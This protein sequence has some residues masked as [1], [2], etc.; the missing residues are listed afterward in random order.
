MASAP[1]STV[2]RFLRSLVAAGP[3]KDLNDGQLLSRFAADRDEIAFEVLMRRHGPL[4]LSVVRRFLGSGP[5]LEDVFQATFLVLARKAG[6]INRQASVASWLYGV[7]FRLAQR[8][9]NRLARQRLRERSSETLEETAETRTMRDNPAEQARLRELGAILD[10]EVERLPRKNREALVLCHLEG[11][12]VAEAA[13]RLGCPLPTLKSRLTR[14][15]ELIRRR[16]VSRGLSVSATT[17]AFIL[18]EQAARAAVPAK[19]MSAAIDAAV[20]FSANSVASAAISAHAAALAKGILKTSVLAKIAFTLCIVL[21]TTLVGFGG[22][23]LTSKESGTAPSPD[24][25]PPA[26]VAFVQPQLIAKDLHGDVLPKGALARLGSTRWHHGAMVR[27]A[28]FLP[29][30]KRVISVSHDEIIHIWDYPSGKE[31]RAFGPGIRDDSQKNVR[32]CFDAALTA[33]GNTIAALF[34]QDGVRFWDVRTG[35]ELPPLAE[36]QK[37]NVLGLA[38]APDGRYLATHDIDFNVRIWDWTVEKEVRSFQ[39]QHKGLAGGPRTLAFA[40]DGKTLLAVVPVVRSAVQIPTIQLWDP[41]TGQR[42]SN[43][44]ATSND[45][46]LPPVFSPNSKLLAYGTGGEKGRG[47]AIVRVE[48]GKEIRRLGPVNSPLNVVFSLDSAKLLGRSFK[49]W[50]VREWDVGNGK[51]MRILGEPQD[52]QSRFGNSTYLALS[53]DGKALLAV[54]YDHALRLVDLNFG[55]TA[56]RL[57]YVLPIR[58][59]AF[60]PD[61]TQLVTQSEA[62]GVSH[63]DVGSGK[64]LRHIAAPP[65]EPASWTV[66]SP[67]GRYFTFN[68]DRSPRF[69]MVIE[70]ATGKQLGQVPGRNLAFSP[71][72]KTLAVGEWERKAICLYDLP[73]LK[74]RCSLP[75]QHVHEPDGESGTIRVGGYTLFFSPDSQ[76]F[77]TLHRDGVVGIWECANGKQVSQFQ[78]G[79]SPI[80]NVAFAPDA[81]ALAIDNRDGTVTIWEVASGQR[82]RVFGLEPVKEI[83]DDGVSGIY[84]P[85]GRRATAATLSYSPDG[86]LVAHAGLHKT[87]HVWDVATGMKAA[88]FHGH[89]GSLLCVAFS[90]DCTRLASGS[91]DTTALIWDVAGLKKKAG[92]APRYQKDAEVRACWEELAGSDAAKAFDAILALAADP[93]QTLLFLQPRLKTAPP[94]DG[95][96]AQLLIAQLDGEQYKVR[97]N[98]A[99]ELRQMGEQVLPLLEKTLAANP[100]LELRRRL[101]AVREYLS[102]LT[103]TGD[104]LR[105]VRSVEVLESIG[106]AQARK[107]LQSLADGPTWALETQT[108]QA[109]LRRWRN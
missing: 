5:D 48:D 40:P 46:D 9:K 76:F 10:E 39:T 37:Q 79:H 3:I 12:S 78:L 108:A 21:S 31:L 77:G 106:S 92:F 54:D 90:P 93:A 98:A 63:W 52:H 74:P 71:D 22:A 45:Q 47:V 27:F 33:D 100:P 66:A 28:A 16:L 61:S 38:F 88:D 20:A 81:R 103:L 7:A 49:D 53:P 30:G 34:Y 26:A 87:V 57:E 25:I 83:K 50:S 104:R 55:E 68:P 67:D 86:K 24:A 73:T 43:L 95:K 41:S 6:S 102:S 42:K 70:A 13:R 105:L 23:L 69:T 29:G 107:V 15:R 99:A 18:A 8:Q 89:S 65:G 72:D 85:Y 35:K 94:V 32:W 36:T 2:Q 14:A 96:R 62:A 60:T 44:E 59:L 4:V 17:L 91:L 75:I 1:F 11:L 82:R 101:E 64:K 97:E 80:Y 84:D 109:A 19:V 56:D 58:N 51:L